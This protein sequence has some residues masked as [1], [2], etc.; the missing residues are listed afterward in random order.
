MSTSSQS[1]YAKFKNNSWCV[2]G[3]H[4][5]GTSN[6]IGDI[7]QN[8]NRTPI[9]LLKGKCTK[10]NRNKSMTVS[11]KTIE[12]EGL[13]DFF[14]HLGKAAK[15]VGKKVLANPGRALEIGAQIGAAAA[16]RNPKAALAATPDVIKF[17][18]TGKGLYLPKFK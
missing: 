6:I 18:H 7:T 9:K 8:K 11:D 17:V 5:S 16:S 3:R 15:S 13:K 4:Y 10:C 14:R 2:G 1:A 12:A